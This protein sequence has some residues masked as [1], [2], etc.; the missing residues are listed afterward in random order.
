MGLIINIII[1]TAC[2]IAGGYQIDLYVKN[3]KFLNLAIG[4]FNVMV[5]TV[6]LLQMV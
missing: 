1:M 4:I 3:K 5:A 6:I 2:F